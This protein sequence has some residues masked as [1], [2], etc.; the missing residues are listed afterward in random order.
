MLNEKEDGPKVSG[1][2]VGDAVGVFGFGA[3]QTGARFV[4]SPQSTDIPTRVMES[5][6]NTNFHTT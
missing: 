3:C 6:E 4:S 5:S 1:N 2:S